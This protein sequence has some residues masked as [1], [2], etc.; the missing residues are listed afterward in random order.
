MF[1]CSIGSVWVFVMGV[2]IVWAYGYVY[3]FGCVVGMGAW[4]YV[5]R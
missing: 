3:S 2:W 1:V 4:V 5:C